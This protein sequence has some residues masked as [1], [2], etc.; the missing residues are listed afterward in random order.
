MLR[1]GC[2]SFLIQTGHS[3]CATDHSVVSNSTAAL[4]CACLQAAC[5]RLS[6]LDAAAAGP[7]RGSQHA[8]SLACR[9]AWCRLQ[10]AWRRRATVTLR[11]ACDSMMPGARW[12]RSAGRDCSGR[13]WAAGSRPGPGLAPSPG[14][15]PLRGSP[16]EGPA[17]P[18]GVVTSGAA[19]NTASTGPVSVP[20]GSRLARPRNL[21][22]CTQGPFKFKQ[23]PS[24]AG[25]GAVGR[26]QRRTRSMATGRCASSLRA[27][28]SE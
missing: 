24:C 4:A 20:L 2:E 7:L 15:G 12:A 22:V 13:H 17:W 9:C 16:A 25:R 10:C 8:P 3:A 23:P 11:H 27:L 14:P 26:G 28:S 1:T 5:L 6:S 21:R 18:P 19:F